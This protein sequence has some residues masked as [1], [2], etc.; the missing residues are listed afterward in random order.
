[1][2]DVD[3]HTLHGLIPFV[4]ALRHYT[5]LHAEGLENVPLKGPALLVANHTGWLGLDYALTALLLHD[6]CERM[7]RGMVHSAWFLTPQTAHF[8]Q[9]VGLSKVSKESMAAELRDG[10]L[11]LVFPEGEKG[12]FRK[13][14]GYRLTEFARGFVRVA[15]QEDVPVVPVAILGGE[16]ANP[17]DR[18]LE[19]YE[20]LL[21]M[22]IPVPRN[23]FPKPVKWRIRF[24]PARRLGAQVPDAG[25]RD[26][27]HAAAEA[28]RA[29]IQ[30]ALDQLKVE[31]GH[32][33]F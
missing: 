17:V 29:E 21:K 16:E 4:R 8:A 10:N 23:L 33:Y 6:E 28:V 25:D 18:T 22:P 30:G 7:P 9:R 27:V 19:S 2:P 5:R 32:P 3:P 26:A 20:Q 15:V 14:T 11:V 24:L 1:M 13:A 12:A 31:R